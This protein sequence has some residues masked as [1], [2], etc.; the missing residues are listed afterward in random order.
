MGIDAAAEDI[1]HPADAH[2]DGDQAGGLHGD[3]CLEGRPHKVHLAL[4]QEPDEPGRSGESPTPPSVVCALTL[5]RDDMLGGVMSRGWLMRHGRSSAR[6]F[7]ILSRLVMIPLA[8]DCPHPF[9]I[10]RPV[11]LFLVVLLGAGNHP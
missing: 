7:M 3:R 5:A 1:C 8:A 9:N 10:L 11:H 6:R 2:R 4:L